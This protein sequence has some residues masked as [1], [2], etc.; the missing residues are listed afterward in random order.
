MIDRARLLGLPFDREI[1]T[2]DW[3]RAAME[4]APNCP[5]CGRAFDFGFKYDG[6][7]KDASPSIDRIRPAEGY[8][9]GNV[10]LICW[11]CNN[12]K[13]DASAAELETIVRW[14][15]ENGAG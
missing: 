1:L 7:K 12:L 11:R 15:R 9:L 4:S 10:A 13:R 14:M 8:V 3:L 5:C 2:T 6:R